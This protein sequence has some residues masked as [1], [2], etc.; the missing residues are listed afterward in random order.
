M[1]PGG[2]SRLAM[3]EHPPPV[4]LPDR[5][6]EDTATSL[7]LLIVLIF[8][9]ESILKVPSNHELPLTPHQS[10]RRSRHEVSIRERESR[11]GHLIPLP[12]IRR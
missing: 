3:P 6:A 1:E 2:V 10:E 9:H 12:H 4:P 11:D 5:R 7:W 8:L